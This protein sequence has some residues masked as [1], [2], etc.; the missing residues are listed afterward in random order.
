MMDDDEDE[1]GIGIDGVSADEIL[2]SDDF[3]E[4]SQEEEYDPEEDDEAGQ[5]YQTIAAAT[6]FVKDISPE[7]AE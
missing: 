1:E 5:Y 3:D 2:D 6:A 7:E 4:D